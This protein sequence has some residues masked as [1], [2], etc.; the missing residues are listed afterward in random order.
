MELRPQLL[1]RV[2]KPPSGED[3]LWELKYDGFRI[4]AH[5]RGGRVRLVTRNGNDFTH[6][7]QG[8]ADS[9]SHL[10]DCVLDGELVMTDAAGR[11]VFPPKSTSPSRAYMVFDIV[12]PDLPLIER[13]QILADLNPP[14][15]VD[16][17]QG[18]GAELFRA[19]CQA[20][21]EGLV[22]KLKTSRYT[23]KRDGTWV[24]IICPNYVR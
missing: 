22:G 15:L 19:V 7:F 8:I 9:L 21:H 17:M 1:T 18:G 23:G 14:N 4:L 12:L 11:C 5:I 3:W 2:E 20:G 24:K 16:F 10:P 13:K 6:K